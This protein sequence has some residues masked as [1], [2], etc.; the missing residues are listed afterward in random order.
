MA[1]RLSIV[2]HSAESTAVIAGPLT[3]VDS[4]RMGPTSAL[5]TITTVHPLEAVQKNYAQQEEALKMNIVG[6][7]QGHYMAQ[8][9]MRE[10][11]ALARPKRLP[12]LHSYNLG[13]QVS[14]GANYSLTFDDYLN[15]PRDAEQMGPV[16]D[17]TEA[18]PY[19]K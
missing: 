15:D 14:T 10:R 2:E 5:A 16:M 3:A 19:F 1:A 7:V 17:M 8:A 4:I 9:L 6:S 12:V 18:S 11:A 13:L